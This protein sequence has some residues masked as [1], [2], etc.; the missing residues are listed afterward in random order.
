MIHYNIKENSIHTWFYKWTT[1]SHRLPESMCNFF[2]T[3]VLGWVLMAL[4]FPLMIPLLCY[5]S[6]RKDPTKV[7][8]MGLFI[9]ELLLFSIFKI[10]IGAF[11][12][13]WDKF[14]EVLVVLAV[15][16]TIIVTLGLIVYGIAKLVEK[17]KDYF[18]DR[19]ISR[20][21]NEERSQFFR[22]EAEKQRKKNQPGFLRTGYDSFMNKHC[23]KIKWIK[24]E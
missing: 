5:K 24:N 16:I 20:M 22:Y 8:P 23:P 4:T 21:S 7:F 9:I 10:T 12:T 3:V 14:L 13:T 1:S 15:A 19:K 6:I 17:T 11:N 2:W 18:Y